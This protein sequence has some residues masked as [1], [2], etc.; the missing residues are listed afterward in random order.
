MEYQELYWYEKNEL[1]FEVTNSDKLKL[2]AEPQPSR[3]LFIPPKSLNIHLLRYGLHKEGE[4][5]TGRSLEME[6]TNRNASVDQP[7]NEKGN[8]KRYSRTWNTC[9]WNIGEEEVIFRPEGA[10]EI[11]GYQYYGAPVREGWLYVYNES[12]GL[13]HEYKILSG[14]ELQMVVWERFGEG[15]DE[16]EPNPGTGKLSCLKVSPTHIVWLAYAEV[17]WTS[18]YTQE[19]VKSKETRE[20]RMQRIDCNEW[21]TTLRG[22]NIRSVAQTWIEVREFNRQYSVAYEVYAH[23]YQVCKAMENNDHHMYVYLHD[24]IGALDDIAQDLSLLYSEFDALVALISSGKS[25]E[26]LLQEMFNLPVSQDDEDDEEP[27]L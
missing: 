7:M 17:Q 13:W 23:N 14:G 2:A 19:T 15:Y 21:V 8:Y 11:P 5:H 25:K 3:P 24:P 16:R 26:E 27:E 9:T 22:E 20:L 12:T 18:K 4:T 10:P 1:E 6:D